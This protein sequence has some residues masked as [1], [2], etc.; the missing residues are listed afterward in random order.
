MHI[1]LR[2]QRSAAIL[3]GFFEV[4][5]DSQRCNIELLNDI[6]AFRIHLLRFCRYQTVYKR[7]YGISIKTVNDSQLTI[8]MWCKFECCIGKNN[9]TTTQNVD[10]AIR[11]EYEYATNIFR[12][13][14]VQQKV[15]I[16][17]S[18]SQFG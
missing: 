1:G 15:C 17:H 7:Q 3:F 9:I 10:V 13:R 5:D 4:D 8:E 11:C 2:K 14:I 16:F 6:K 18:Y 12:T